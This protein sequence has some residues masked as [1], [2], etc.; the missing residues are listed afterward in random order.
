MASKS[1]KANEILNTAH[2]I[3]QFAKKLIPSKKIRT[4]IKYFFTK[5][6][7]KSTADICE[8][9]EIRPFLINEIYKE[10][11]LNLEK[12]I[13]RDLSSWYNL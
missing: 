8:L 12:L 7:Q 4:N 11:I 2:P 9:E 6:N 1:I 13:D 10:S 5:L 3:N